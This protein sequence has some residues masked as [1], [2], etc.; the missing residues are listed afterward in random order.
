VQKKHDPNE[1]MGHIEGGWAKQVDGAMTEE[2]NEC[3]K[4]STVLRVMKTH[5][6]EFMH[7][8][9]NTKIHR[10]WLLVMKTEFGNKAP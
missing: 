10:F 5:G 2:S 4:I 1:T 7:N 3:K 6:V 8:L 9:S